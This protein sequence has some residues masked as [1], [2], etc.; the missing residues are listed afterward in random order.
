MSVSFDINKIKEKQPEKL[1]PFLNLLY[2]G[3][4]PYMNNG[5][6]GIVQ[7]EL[8]RSLNGIIKIN[9]QET[10]IS[11]IGIISKSSN[12]EK[13]VTEIGTFTKTKVGYVLTEKEANINIRKNEKII[14]LC[15]DTKQID[16]NVFIGFM[17]GKNNFLFLPNIY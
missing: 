15:N 12:S 17:Q 14:D 1:F 13:I 2:S 11:K 6:F 7:N 3:W 10:H 8:L 16:E 4:L 5:E 9:N